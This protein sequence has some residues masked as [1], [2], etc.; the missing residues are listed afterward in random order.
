M[1]EGQRDIK[2]INQNISIS[3]Y[4]TECV[5]SRRFQDGGSK[6]I[7]EARPIDQYHAQTQLSLNYPFKALNFNYTGPEKSVLM[8]ILLQT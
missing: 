5:V 2:K 3:L 4:Y 7:V 1:Y 6:K 8:Y